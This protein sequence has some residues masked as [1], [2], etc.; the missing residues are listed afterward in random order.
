MS[1]EVGTRN[2]EAENELYSKQNRVLMLNAN[3]NS[4]RTFSNYFSKNNPAFIN[5]NMG[6]MLL[7]TTQNEKGRLMPFQG[8]NGTLNGQTVQNFK[9]S[10]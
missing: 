7:E 5:Q 1:Q 9:D 10:T 8:T 2:T 3:S 4:S 6:A